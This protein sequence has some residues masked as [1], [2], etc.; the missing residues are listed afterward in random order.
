MDVLY[1]LGKGSKNNND[2]IRYSL[3]SLER[4]LKNYNRVIVVG[5]DTG[6]F[7]DKIEFHHLP[8]YG[9]NKQYRI[10]K[11][12]EWACN[13]VLKGDFFFMNDDFFFNRSVSTLTYPFYYKGSLFDFAPDPNYSRALRN[14]G[15]FL[16][17]NRMTYK[18]FDV[19]TPIIYNTE[20][21]L[22]LTQIWRKSGLTTHG[23][24]VKSIYSNWYGVK[25]NKY[26]DVKLGEMDMK[27]IKSTNC[28]SC[29]DTGWDNGV[30][31]YVK[32]RFN[33]PSCFEIQ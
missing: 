5:E 33:T 24:V 10:A 32:K 16:R 12:I 6:F 21:Y 25:G 22:K 8:E 7:S 15:R 2:E 17:D 11:K 31:D 28:F 3:R 19:H 20:N 27:K 1:I 18:H 4:Y 30:G 29:S 26:T 9:G 13:N 23:Y 14:T